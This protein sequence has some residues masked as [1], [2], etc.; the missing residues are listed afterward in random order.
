MLS[1]LHKRVKQL[2]GKPRGNPIAKPVIAVMLFAIC[3][4]SLVA[5]AGVGDIVDSFITGILSMMSSILIGIC[6][7]L[8]GPIFE[9][10]TMTIDDIASYIP[11]FNPNSE[12]GDFFLRALQALGNCIAFCLA[13]FSILQLA[14]SLISNEKVESIS[15][16]LWR[17][18]VFAPLTIYG[19]TLLEII[20]DYVISP[21]S[22]AFAGGVLSIGPDNTVFADI[23]AP[24]VNETN[25]LAVL[26]VGTL[27]IVMIGYNIIALVLE[28]AERY[29]ICIFLIFLSPLAF[30]AGVN[31]S[32]TQVAKNWFRMF[33][34]QCVLLILNIWVVGIARTCLGTIDASA[35]TTEFICWAIISYAYLKIAQRLDDILQNSGLLITRT[36]GDFMQD[37]FV[38]ASSLVATAKLAGDVTR[39]NSDINKVRKN[40]PDGMARPEDI[41]VPIR[42]FQN[43]HPVL[44]LPVGA[45][46]QL[47]NK[48]VN[49]A[50]EAFA[51]SK[52]RHTS[53]STR[54][55]SR[56]N[57]NLSSAAYRGAAQNALIK[58]GRTMGFDK[59]G[60]KGAQIE[61]LA[62]NPDGTL[63]GTLVQ[64]D[65][66]GNIAR[67]VGFTMSNPTG[68]ND[69]IAFRHDRTMTMAPDGKSAIIEDS[70]T[71]TY[72]LQQTG[73]DANG[74]QVWSATHVSDAKGN[75]VSALV[76]GYNNTTEFAFRPDNKQTDGIAAQAASA[77]VSGGSYD[78]LNQNMADVANAR[79]DIFA[80]DAARSAGNNTVVGDEVHLA[81]VDGILKGDEN[82]SFGDSAKVEN[83]EQND[84]GSL[85][86]H[87]VTRNAAGEIEGETLHNISVDDDGHMSISDVGQ[88]QVS[89]DGKNAVVENEN[90]TFQ[91]SYKNNDERGNQ[92]W[93]ASRIFDENG[94]SIEA[95]ESGTQR[96]TVRP[97]SRSEDGAASQAASQFVNSS[98]LENTVQSSNDAIGHRT[99]VARDF[100]EASNELELMTDNDRLTALRSAGSD[101]EP[102]HINFSSEGYRRAV[103]SYMQTHN[104]LKDDDILE[105]GGEIISQELTEDGSLSGVIALRD[106]NNRITE[107]RHFNFSTEL[108][109]PVDTRTPESILNDSASG[110]SEYTEMRKIVGS[111]EVTLG[112]KYN[113]VDDYSG[114]IETSDIGKATLT[115]VS[116]DDE[117]GDSKWQLVRRGTDSTSESGNIVTFERKGKRGESE[118]F[119]DVVKE[120]KHAKSFDEAALIDFRNKIRPAKEGKHKK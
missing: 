110:N 103:A 68:K 29:L 64:R 13:A 40:S 111:A 119:Y 65:A 104:C 62:Q 43:N 5:Y 105:R 76:P 15:S 46:A 9:I 71:G 10:T 8:I 35:G 83:I 47:Q 92:V 36:G 100:A 93:E 90:G 32:T 95:S 20:F 118:S 81:A 99:S 87:M 72:K 120:L 18:F 89:A 34:S 61:S 101:D 75:D 48:C 82:H 16:V 96:F 60:K 94:Q 24:I 50:T 114:Y 63:S 108:D 78:A 73:I 109:K 106:E 38:A 88:M 25:G 42:N 54:A 69:D 49:F 3:I 98:V 44:G 112:C 6:D 86:A 66:R 41:A 97:N 67:Q 2:T 23:A 27:L 19:S 39:L 113:A 57:V 31:Q 30:A 70:K 79:N 7:M 80:S 102:A 55:G 52:L 117:T 51:G 85:T 59:I 11:G 45:A 84:N 115:R 12:L 53:D 37:A 58:S 107:E 28:A 116:V 26:I 21:I 33:W 14:L 74:R 77:F 56:G 22:T 17:I 4:T 1:I 91:L